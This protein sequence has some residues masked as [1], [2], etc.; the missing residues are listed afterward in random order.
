MSTFRTDRNNNPTAFTTEIAENA[1]LVRGRDYDIGDPF[2]VD[3]RTFFTA[4]LLGDPVALTL[5]VIDKI[6]FYTHL[7]GQ[8]W[9]YIGIPPN[10]WVLF[11]AAARAE[12]IAYMYH[13]EGGTE[14]LPVINAAVQAAMDARAGGY[15]KM[16]DGTNTPVSGIA[17]LAFAS[18]LKIWSRPD[19]TL[20]LDVQD[21][22]FVII[23]N[24]D[25]IATYNDMKA[26][27]IWLDGFLSGINVM[28]K[29]RKKP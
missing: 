3:G 20:A 10:I 29:V 15:K 8:R 23:C 28:D 9:T 16:D 22:N 25:I 4:R 14:L 26:A 1:G 27:G 13:R 21:G 7:G 5:Q 12:T 17:L 6:T 18:R 24:G 2:E 19:L 11:D